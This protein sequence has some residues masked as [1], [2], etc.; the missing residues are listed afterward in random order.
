MSTVRLPTSC[1][2]EDILAFARRW[3]ESL[4]A[5]EYT[6]A[7]EMLLTVLTHPGKSWVRTPAELTA[8]VINYGSPD[9]IPGEP[10]CAVTSIESARGQ[11][12]RSLPSLTRRSDDEPLRYPGCRGRLDWQLPLDGEWSDLVASFDLIEHEQ[13]LAMVL[14]SLRVP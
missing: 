3:T 1:S 11:P 2:D 5:E 13:D 14:V 4:V 7:F 12:W 6:E 9:P 8:W 10:A